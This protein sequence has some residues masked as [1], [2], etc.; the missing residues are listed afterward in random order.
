M[1]TITR[2]KDRIKQKLLEVYGQTFVD[3]CLELAIQVVPNTKPE[4]KQFTHGVD[5]VVKNN[6]RIGVNKKLKGRF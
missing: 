2:P 1:T 4:P 5:K 3:Q 6:S